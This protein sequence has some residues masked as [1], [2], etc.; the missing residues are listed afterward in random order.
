MR[1]TD[2]DQAENINLS[3]LD[4]EASLTLAQCEASSSDESSTCTDD[5]EKMIE[6]QKAKIAMMKKR[7][8]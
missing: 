5:L 2:S 8:D 3:N 1:F 6:A 7:R 4:N